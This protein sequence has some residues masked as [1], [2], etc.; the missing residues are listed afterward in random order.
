MFVQDVA[1]TSQTTWQA[2]LNLSAMMERSDWG[3]GAST[4]NLVNGIP[5]LSPPDAPLHP[6]PS[7][8]AASETLDPATYGQSSSSALYHCSSLPGANEPSA[9]PVS[10]YMALAP[11]PPS[12]D[13]SSWHTTRQTLT[14]TGLDDCMDPYSSL[15]SASHQRRGSSPMV[16]PRV[17]PDGFS[18]KYRWR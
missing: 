16:V 5:S 10:T 2:S 6:H 13:I 11:Q 1:S 3:D 15:L 7:L 17:S 8:V 9:T 18:G 12:S 4:S 14:T